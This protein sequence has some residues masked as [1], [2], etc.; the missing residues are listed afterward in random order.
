MYGSAPTLRTVAIMMRTGNESIDQWYCDRCEDYRS[1]K[2]RTGG[3]VFTGERWQWCE[4]C[5]DEEWPA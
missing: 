1:T 3:N 2:A 4:E 5:W